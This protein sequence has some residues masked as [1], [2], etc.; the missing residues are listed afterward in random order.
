MKKIVFFKPSLISTLR[1]NSIGEV[2]VV[3]IV[4]IV[5]IPLSRKTLIIVMEGY[6]LLIKLR[7]I[8]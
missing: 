5:L 4:L 2:V 1:Y 8:F 3:G 7:L 6:L